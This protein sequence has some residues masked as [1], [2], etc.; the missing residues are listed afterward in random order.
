V[1]A[2]AWILALVSAFFFGLALV[3][4]Q[5]GLRSMAA[6]QGAAVSIPVSAALCWCLAP[7]AVDFGAWDAGAAGIFA[8]VGLFFPATVTILTFEAN[9][10][11]GPAVAGAVGN[12][13]PLFAVLIAVAVLGETLTPLMGLGIA[14]VVAGVAM[15]SLGRRNGAAGWPAWALALPVLSAMIRGAVQPAVKLG[16]AAW[17]SP[18]AAVAIGYA[19]SA[20]VVLSVA[21][22]R[23]R[24]ASAAF[25]RRG[26]AWFAAVGVC[27]VAAVFTLYAALAR[28]PVTLVSPMVASYPLVTLAVG[29][30]VLHAARPG[31]AV[32]LGVAVTVGGI[33]LLLLRG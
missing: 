20:V 28:G 24:G 10:R 12:L 26:A 3:L 15:M 17:N 32:L 7:F 33:V 19:V 8:A 14:A 2:E 27:N 21:A 1:A 6:V 16:M 11:M 4:T 9:R 18:L 29:W 13:A 23:S 22:V 31:R 30:V 5:F 25:N